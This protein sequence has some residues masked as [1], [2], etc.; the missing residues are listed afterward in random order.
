MAGWS[1]CVSEAGL[2][3]GKVA[4]ITGAGSG[5]GRATAVL[6]AAEGAVGVV[7]SD[8]SA[9]RAAETV[10]DIRAAGGSA[11]AMATDVTDGS[12][13][14]A[15][16][17]AAFRTWGRVD[18]AVNNAGVSGPKQ[19]L[20]E[21]HDEQWRQVIDVNLSGVFY[22]I[23]AA[24]AVMAGRGGA[25]VNVASGAAVHPPAGLGPYAAS[26]AGVV[27]LTRSAAADYARSGIRINS[28]L[29]GPTRTP[30]WESNLVGDAVTATQAREARLPM[31]RAGRPGE[32]AEAIVWL[33]SDRASYVHGVDLLVDGGSHAFQF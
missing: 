19:P 13:V 10:E 32:I 9:D 8:L 20:G 2:V 21:Y 1:E 28:V 33:C 23:R 4:V 15:L 5:I 11:L 3:A 30:L 29:P 7:V 6:L 18:C 14:D 27:G 26:K 16:F 17:E 31:G 24:V 22:G 12:Q 25:I